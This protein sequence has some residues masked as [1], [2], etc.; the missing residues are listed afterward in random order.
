MALRDNL[1]AYYKLDW[2]ANDDLWNNN[3]TAT[4]IIY[5]TGRK[6]DCATLDSTW[7]S[8]R[9]WINNQSSIMTNSWAFTVS[10]WIKKTTS[11]TD[12]NRQ[13]AFF[14]SG[15]SNELIYHFIE[16]GGPNTFTVYFADWWSA[17]SINIT[18][19]W[20]LD[21]FHHVVMT[22]TWTTVKMFFDWIEVWNWTSSSSYNGF[23]NSSDWFSVW[24]LRGDSG[25]NQIGWL[26][27]EV[28]L[29]NRALSST[30]VT[31]LYEYY[32]ATTA[33]TTNFF[34]FLM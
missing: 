15:G 14:A 27:D 26:I 2:N 5:V 18:H 7:E 4:N 22:W 16:S 34:N 10:Y 11:F 24:C 6:W 1:I 23:W 30:E 21:E 17:S 20:A 19:W 33:N 31:E 12:S 29:W 8:F 28:W 32:P 25:V 3:W 9:F 13:W